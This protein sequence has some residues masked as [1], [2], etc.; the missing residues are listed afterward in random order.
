MNGRNKGN[1]AA[2]IGLGQGGLFFQEGKEKRQAPFSGRPAWTYRWWVGRY[3]YFNRAS[4]ALQLIFL[5]KD[6]I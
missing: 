4:A 2:G 3:A 1:R 6:S 5:K